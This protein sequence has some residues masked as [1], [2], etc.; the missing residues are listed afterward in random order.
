MQ[1]LYIQNMYTHNIYTHNI[2]IYDS[3]Y[4]HIHSMYAHVQCIFTCKIL[5]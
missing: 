3:L 2:Y 1:Y 5:L 4:E